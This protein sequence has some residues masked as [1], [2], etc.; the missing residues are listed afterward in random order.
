M[1]RAFNVENVDGIYDRSERL[2]MKTIEDIALEVAEEVYDCRL[3]GGAAIR[4]REFINKFMERMAELSE[5][6]VWIDDRDDAISLERYMD[7]PMEKP[8]FPL[9]SHPAPQPDMLLR[10][11]LTEEAREMVDMLRDYPKGKPFTYRWEELQMEAAD[12][13]EKLAGLK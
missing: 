8:C 7:E 11:E 2:E 9:A 4:M 13:I 10:S 3:K 12:L 5:P 1:A 6:V